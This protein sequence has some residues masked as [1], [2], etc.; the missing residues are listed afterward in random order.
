VRGMIELATIGAINMDISIFV[1]EFAEV[2][3]RSP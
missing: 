1:D 3:G 2:G